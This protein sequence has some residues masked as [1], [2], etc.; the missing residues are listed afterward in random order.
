[1]TFIHYPNCA[2]SACVLSINRDTYRWL[3]EKGER[4]LAERSADSKRYVNPSNKKRTHVD[5]L[6]DS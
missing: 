5:D 6:Q 4:R 3:L 2:F 1:M